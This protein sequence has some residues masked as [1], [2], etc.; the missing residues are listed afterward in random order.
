[1]WGSATGGSVMWSCSRRCWSRGLRRRARG[2]LAL[3]AVVLCAFGPPRVGDR[4]GV[5]DFEARPGE[6]QAIRRARMPVLTAKSA[7]LMD[8]A[9]GRVLYGKAMHQ[10]LPPAS[11]T[12]MM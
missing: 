11:T 10:R 8:F 6:L 4:L 7:V 5:P 1:M 12:K 9:S 2:W 3:L